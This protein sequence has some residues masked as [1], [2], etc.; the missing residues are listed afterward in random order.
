MNMKA[1]TS[2]MAAGAALLCAVASAQEPFDPFRLLEPKN[3]TAPRAVEQSRP[4]FEPAGS[5]PVPL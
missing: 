2:L 1:R 3:F 5:H 4:R